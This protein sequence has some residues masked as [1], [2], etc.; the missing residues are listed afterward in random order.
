VR[1]DAVDDYKKVKFSPEVLEAIENPKTYFGLPEKEINK[2]PSILWDSWEHRDADDEA[3]LKFCKRWEADPGLVGGDK[4]AVAWL[5]EKLKKFAGIIERFAND[6]LRASDLYEI[7]DKLE[8]KINPQ[9]DRDAHGEVQFLEYRSYERAV[10]SEKEKKLPETADIRVDAFPYWLYSHLYKFMWVEK[11]K[12]KICAA[13]DCRQLF[14]PA[15]K[16]ELRQQYH[17]STCRSRVAK[18]RE[19]SRTT[20]GLS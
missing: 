8:I 14:L 19:R 18:R 3:L 2:I 20:R 5:R 13:E 7:T 9:T 12:L 15:A 11:K 10:D 1:D 4:A 17:S 6:E 16:N